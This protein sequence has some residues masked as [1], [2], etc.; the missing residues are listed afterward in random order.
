M[1]RSIGCGLVL[2]YWAAR[3]WLFALIWT[4][5]S[6]DVDRGLEG[7]KAALFG[8]RADW[9]GALRGVVLEIGAG[10]GAN[11]RYFGRCAEGGITSVLLNEP[12]LSMHAA[13]RAEAEA[14]GLTV[15]S[16]RTSNKSTLRLLGG[17]AEFM[18][19]KSGSVD[20]VVCTLVLCSVGQPER[21]L[22][23]VQRVLKPG[24]RLLFMEHVAAP[25]GSEL[26]R[27][28]D[29]WGPLWRLLP[30]DGCR[31]NCETDVLVKDMG[32][33]A[34]VSTEHFMDHSGPA[35]AAPT[36]MGC[37]VKAQ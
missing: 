30:L 5:V 17:S 10:V 12:H 14:C 2:A 24:G 21:V 11:L 20:V 25:R 28:Q 16:A 27:R 35:V 37:A 36:A 33:W 32:G 23:E 7:Q 22:R 18:R 19:I 4:S 15:P 6:K 31:I 26:R 3:S 13:L 29:R 9:G 1:W 34:S 8:G